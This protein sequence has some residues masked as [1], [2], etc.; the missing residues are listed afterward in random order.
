MR[1][2]FLAL[3]LLLPALLTS[4]AAW[5]ITPESTPLPTTSGTELTSQDTPLP[6]TTPPPYSS[7]IPW[8]PVPISTFAPVVP[9]LPA[10]SADDVRVMRDRHHIEAPTEQNRQDAARL[11][12]L[13]SSPLFSDR[14]AASAA[15]RQALTSDPAEDIVNLYWNVSADAVR[16]AFSKLIKSRI[17]LERIRENGSLECTRR[18]DLHYAA[19]DNNIGASLNLI[20]FSYVVERALEDSLHERLRLTGEVFRDL[21]RALDSAIYWSELNANVWEISNS[22]CLPGPLNRDELLNFYRRLLQQSADWGCGPAAAEEVFALNG[23]FCHYLMNCHP[24]DSLL[25]RLSPEERTI[26]RAELAT[27][28]VSIESGRAKVVGFAEDPQPRVFDLTEL[29][30]PPETLLLYALAQDY[31]T[32]ADLPR[33]FVAQTYTPQITVVGMV[34]SSAFLNYGYLPEYASGT[35]FLS[36]A[37]NDMVRALFGLPALP[38]PP[39]VT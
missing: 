38:P 34:G 35:L 15:I 2:L 17:L 26:V 21:A 4:R 31:I 9:P 16:A 39:E 6:A 20:G 22:S 3:C 5:A 7:P 27:S 28:A 19:L 18:V 8:A 12:T 33:L 32:T 1:T 11:R 30:F 24:D 37:L 13:L 14:E 10:I 36:R 25:S 29:G 23:G